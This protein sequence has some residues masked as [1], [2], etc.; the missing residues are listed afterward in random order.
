[1]LRTLDSFVE[2][3][4][5]H[6]AETI[7]VAFVAVFFNP[8]TNMFSIFGTLGSIKR[9]SF[10]STMNLDTEALHASR[11]HKGKGKGTLLV[12]YT[13]LLKFWSLHLSLL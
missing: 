13:A 8:L 11:R 12:T 9:M 5:L 6:N 1:M 2:T 10:L 3:V 4:I 7:N